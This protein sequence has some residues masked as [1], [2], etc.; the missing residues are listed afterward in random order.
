MEKVRRKLELFF[1]YEDN[2]YTTGQ[3]R[4]Y[5]ANEFIE[6]DNVSETGDFLLSEATNRTF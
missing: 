4:R 3:I 6:K 5:E 2:F 1:V